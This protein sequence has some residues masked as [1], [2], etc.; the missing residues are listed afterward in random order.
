MKKE[1][2][3]RIKE[4][5]LDFT[6]QISVVETPGEIA[7]ADKIYE[8]IAA[9]D[10]YKKHP[11]LVYTLDCIGD[12][13]GRK[14]VVAELNGEKAPSD[15]TVVMIGHFDTVGISDYGNLK[16]YAG[17]P[18]K[19]A[20]ELKNI[21]LPPEAKED[22]ESGKYLFGRGLFD[23]KSGDAA[24]IGIMEEIS[25]DI[26]N[27]EGNLIYC[28]VCDEES[29][30][31]G[32]LNFVPHL[33][34]LREEKHYD[35]LAMI[36]PDYMAPAYPGDPLKYVY[37]G[38]VGKIMP[39]FYIVGK[40]THVGE[41]FDGLDPNQIAAQLTCRINLNPEF[42][43]VVNGEVTLPPVTLKQRDLKTE[44]SVQTATKSI[45]MFN[46][47][48][49][50]SEPNEVM[51]K[52]KAAAQEEFQKVVD[53]LNERYKVFCQMYNR[54]FRPQ[55][56]V[57]RTMTYRELKDAVRKELPDLDGRIDE[58]IEELRTDTTIDVREK[59]YRL[60][61]YVH[62]LWSDRNPVIIV[63][64]TPPYYP[65]IAVNDED[66]R[67][68]VLIDAVRSAI[69]TVKTD[70]GFDYQLIEKRFLPCISDLSYASAPTDPEV[71]EDYEENT[72]GYAE[73]GIYYLPL[74]KMQQLDLPVTD[75][76]TVGKDAHKF[77]ERIDPRFTFEY[78]PEL[79]YQTILN[80]LN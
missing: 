39:T 40:E 46:Y 38:T 44:Y 28:A 23:M 29:N 57:A 62:S 13:Y 9:I 41:S 60:V 69:E 54:E 51:A 74:D 4:M 64:F 80:L 1:V 21:M 66:P 7:M 15:K 75:I 10:Y 47:A 5:A 58:K 3:Q 18:E 68:K 56:W 72:P 45:L 43:D 77:T 24:I 37:V 67:D 52:M 65:H 16:D 34:K 76:G 20:E 32:M 17:N 25:K 11:E 8:T 22:L 71:L 63:Y 33:I 55:P 2:S 50:C 73:D 49:H 26:E 30:S 78:T 35:Y 27:F 14:I 12:Q 31:T 61:D 6:S 59:S 48:T 70:P 53:T 79:I 19:L 42:S 36:D